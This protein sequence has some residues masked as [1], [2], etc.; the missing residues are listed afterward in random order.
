MKIIK[1]ILIHLALALISFSMFSQNKQDAGFI[2][3]KKGDTLYGW[4]KDIK[5]ENMDRPNSKIRIQLEKGKKSKHKLKTIS[6]IERG[7]EIF[8]TFWLEKNGSVFNEKYIVTNNK[9]DFQL[10]K[11]I[12]TGDLSHY[13]KLYIDQESGVFESIDFLKLKNSNV[14]IRATQGVFGLKKKKVAEYLNNCEAIVTKIKSEEVKTIFD[15]VSYYNNY[16][17]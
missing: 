5:I 12:S 17:D 13:I 7:D 11:C 15:V 16:C 2:I 9:G 4:I 1:Y 8:E 3:T 14:I 10:L 6:I